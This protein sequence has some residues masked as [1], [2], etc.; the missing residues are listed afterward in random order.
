MSAS[1]KSSS[2]TA[3]LASRLFQTLL[4]LCAVLVAAFVAATGMVN[5]HVLDWTM[6][7]IGSLCLMPVLIILD[8]AAVMA[9]CLGRS[10]APGHAP[11][12]SMLQDQDKRTDL[13]LRLSTLMLL[14][15][16]TAGLAVFLLAVPASSIWVNG[17]TLM[18]F[19]AVFLALC[20]LSVL[21]SLQLPYVVVNMLL[22]LVRAKKQAEDEQDEQGADNV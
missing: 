17:I 12:D 10:H 20:S 3:K 11:D 7:G 21:L 8:I 2:F 5:A 18:R 1:K 16:I 15:V 6:L 22:P 19:R 9:A 14:H 4:F 13:L